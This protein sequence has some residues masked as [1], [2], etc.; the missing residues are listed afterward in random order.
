[1]NERKSFIPEVGKVYENAGG[2]FY[3][4]TR[5]VT[6]YDPPAITMKNIRSGWTCDVH[7]LGIYPDG[8]IDWDRSSGGRFAN[9]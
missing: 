2:G 1:M 5:S 8:R 4:C 6:A 9:G 3:E 7:G